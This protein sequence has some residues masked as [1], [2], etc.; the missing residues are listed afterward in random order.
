MNS[1]EQERID[2][3]G[4]I[5]M[6]DR[7]TLSAAEAAETLGI[8]KTKMYELINREDC[9]FAFMLGGRRLISRS[10][11]EAWVERQTEAKAG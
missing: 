6:S 9:D 2:I 8:S 3:Q 4:G 1:K 7:I 5:M 11:L 10:K